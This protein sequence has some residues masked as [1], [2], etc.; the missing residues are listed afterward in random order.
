MA[1]LAYMIEMNDYCI[2]MWFLSVLHYTVSIFY[3]SPC[4]IAI[5]NS[6]CTKSLLTFMQL[7]CIILMDGEYCSGSDLN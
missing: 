2:I 1:S 5:A 7:Y 6:M 4:V 3:H